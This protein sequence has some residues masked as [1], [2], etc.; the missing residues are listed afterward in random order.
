MWAWLGM[1]LIPFETPEAEGLVVWRGGVAVAWV[2]GAR[3]RWLD[4]VYDASEQTLQLSGADLQLCLVGGDSW[5]GRVHWR[6]PVTPLPSTP[7]RA[8]RWCGP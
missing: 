5:T 2:E 8:D 3:P 7:P 4:G 6:G 1:Q